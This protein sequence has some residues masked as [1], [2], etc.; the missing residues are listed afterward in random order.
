MASPA[1]QEDAFQDFTGD[2]IKGFQVTDSDAGGGPTVGEYV[3]IHHMYHVHSLLLALWH[4][5]RIWT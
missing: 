3:Q 5:L 2:G 4:A 1:F